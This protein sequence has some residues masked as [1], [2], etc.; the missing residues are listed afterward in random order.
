MRDPCKI[1][2][3]PLYSAVPAGNSVCHKDGSTSLQPKT[4]PQD[5]LPFP[6][7]PHVLK[8]YNGLLTALAE[9][10]YKTAQSYIYFYIIYKLAL[11]LA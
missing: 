9:K 3:Q 5:F 8:C 7:L 6:L 10:Q 11:S 1:Q 2:L 4:S